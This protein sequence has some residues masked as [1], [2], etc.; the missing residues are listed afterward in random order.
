MQYRLAHKLMVSQILQ[1]VPLGSVGPPSLWAEA[2]LS[3]RSVKG[4]GMTFCEAI[5]NYREEL[6]AKGFV[7]GISGGIDSAPG[8]TW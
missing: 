1:T 8:F 6:E 5:K 4:G 7:I 2:A 3:R